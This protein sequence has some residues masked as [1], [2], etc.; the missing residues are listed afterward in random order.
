MGGGLKHDA[1]DLL[2]N[3]RSLNDVAAG[4]SADIVTLSLE[5]PL[6]WFPL[7]LIAEIESCI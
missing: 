4:G 3:L 7:L 1:R 2:W 6:V 5:C